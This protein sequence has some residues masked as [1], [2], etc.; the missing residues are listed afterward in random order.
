MA[1]IERDPSY[2][3]QL[4][5]V[6]ESAGFRAAIFP[7]AK[8]V[9]PLLR[10]RQF[11][12]VLLDLRV[13]DVDPFALCREAGPLVPTIALAPACAGDACMRA[14]EA[15]AHD[16][17]CREFSD[18]ELLARIHNL[19]RRA[20]QPASGMAAVVSEMR[21]RL[22]GRVQKLTAGE[23][24]VLAALLDHAPRP[25]TTEEIARAIGA[26]RGTVEARIKSLRGKLGAERLVSRGRF[27]YEIAV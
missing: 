9:L 1:I 10:E 2:A 21:V 6:L 27:G 11:A 5:R 7:A 18:R 23:T 25:M 4:L 17:L 14:L 15:G 8:P 22:D 20:E 12:L 16:C 26:S 3:V 19:L 24:A 13:D